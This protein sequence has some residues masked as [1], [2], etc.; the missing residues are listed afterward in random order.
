M[1]LPAFRL[2]ASRWALCCRLLRKLK[3]RV[4]HIRLGK[5][6]SIP[7]PLILI[8]CPT[9][10]RNLQRHEVVRD[11]RAREDGARLAQQL[12]RREWI[13]RRIARADVRQ[14]Q[15]PHVR[16]ARDLSRLCCG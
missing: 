9:V 1:L 4:T 6:F 5:A 16:A 2:A 11:D 13:A 10:A 8:P 3:A 14:Y 15:L 7:Q 12:L